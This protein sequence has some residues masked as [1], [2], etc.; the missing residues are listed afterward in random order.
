MPH[1][2]TTWCHW[3][4]TTCI[5]CVFLSAS[6]SNPVCSSTRHC[7]AWLQSTSSRC[8]YQSRRPW[9]NHRCAQRQGATS[10]FHALGSSS[11]SAPSHSPVRRLG[12][13]PDVVRSAESIDT[14]KSRLKSFLFSV[15]YPGLSFSVTAC[16]ASSAFLAHPVSWMQHAVL[17]RCNKMAE[18]T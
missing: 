11:A 17:N 5:G 4:A 12:S 10:S 7:T 9:Q 13:L 3:F 15:S 14:F 16:S 1:A 8:V 6:R 2:V 18:N